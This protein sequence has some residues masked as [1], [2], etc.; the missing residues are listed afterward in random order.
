MEHVHAATSA[1]GSSFMRF[2]S[3]RNRLLMVLKN[4]P[5]GFVLHAFASLGRRAAAAA[6]GG[7]QP[8]THHSRVAVLF[9]FLA[10]APMALARRI[11]IRG[12][13]KVA[14]AEVLRWAY[15]RERWDARS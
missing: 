7:D 14:D 13:R 6:G 2:H 3:E 4:A 15:P 9:S 11:R 12:R 8:A 10:L 1:A 5:L